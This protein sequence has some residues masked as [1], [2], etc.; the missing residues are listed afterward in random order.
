MK[1]DTVG[2]FQFWY[3]NCDL[4]ER[5]TVLGTVSPLYYSDG[6]VAVTP[7]GV[8]KSTAATAVAPFPRRPRCTR[9]RPCSSRP[10][11]PARRRRSVRSESCSYRTRS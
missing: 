11:S 2:E 3:E 9:T 6:G 1:A 8:G 5:L 4:D 7:T 10:V